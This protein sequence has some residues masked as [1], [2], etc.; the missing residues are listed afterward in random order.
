[1]AIQQGILSNKTSKTENSTTLPDATQENLASL[2]IIR[3]RKKDT[4][5]FP[6]ENPCLDVGKSTNETETLPRLTLH[7]YHLIQTRWKWIKTLKE[8]SELKQ[9]PLDVP[10][11]QDHSS[12]VNVISAPTPYG[13]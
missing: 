8:Y 9:Y 11:T 7:Q 13:N 3:P 4:L 6:N 10:K 2:Q 12:A 1:M 5:D